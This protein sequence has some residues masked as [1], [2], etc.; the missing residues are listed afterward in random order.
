MEINRGTDCGADRAMRWPVWI[1]IRWAGEDNIGVWNL[2]SS[3]VDTG[4]DCVIL[5]LG[6]MR[7]GILGLGLLDFLL[8]LEIQKLDIGTFLREFTHR[9]SR[10]YG[11][12]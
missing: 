12:W 1:E 10:V 8:R 3:A 2:Q 6:G 4:L 11:A 9:R 7:V 5:V